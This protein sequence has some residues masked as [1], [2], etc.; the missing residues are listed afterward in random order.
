MWDLR[1]WLW[2]LGGPDNSFGGIVQNNIRE[3]IAGQEIAD[4]RTAISCND[5][6]LFCS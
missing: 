4:E 3:L 1:A 2:I 5:Q 6:H